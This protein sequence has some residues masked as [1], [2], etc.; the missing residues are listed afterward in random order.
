M[1]TAA[2]SIEGGG[3]LERAARL[4]QRVASR[5]GPG[6]HLRDA[7]AGTASARTDTYFAA[8]Q[9]TTSTSSPRSSGWTDGVVVSDSYRDAG[10]PS[11]TYPHPG[12]SISLL[13][14]A[15][16]A[17]GPDELLPR[18]R[19]PMAEQ[20]PELPISPTR[21]L[22][23]NVEKGLRVAATGQAPSSLS[24]R[25]H[26]HHHHHPQQQQQ[27]QHQR[28]QHDF[29][30]DEL[31]PPPAQLSAVL[32]QRVRNRVLRNFRECVREHNLRANRADTERRA[33]P[34]RFGDVF[35][36]RAFFRRFIVQQLRGSNAPVRGRLSSSSFRRRCL[37]R[38]PST[39]VLSCGMIL[40]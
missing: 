28:G 37:V 8:T 27:Q 22:P 25:H 38:R 16:A 33:L 3:T 15:A 10:Q 2:G 7:V 30:P 13:A 40:L 17:I 9:T 18:R 11:M 23:K 21:P 14:D 29:D 4:R 31:L 35:A 39:I 1:D 36:D 20:Q 34:A 12:R 5:G 26:R 19:A 6:A 32:E 24:H